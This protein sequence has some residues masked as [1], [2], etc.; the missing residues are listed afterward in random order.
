M[1]E[2]SKKKKKTYTYILYIREKKKDK[3]NTHTHIARVQLYVS[4]YQINRSIC[5]TRTEGT[6]ITTAAVRWR[7]QQ[8]TNHALKRQK[9]HAQQTTTP[10]CAVCRR[11][12]TYTISL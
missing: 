12:F 1:H 6:G 7:I 9:K 4:I 2:K 8:Y 5:H 11:I 10:R 3:R